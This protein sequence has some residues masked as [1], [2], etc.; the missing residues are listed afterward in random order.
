MLPLAKK[1]NL[2]Y[3]AFGED[4]T[5]ANVPAK[6]RLALT[7]PRFLDPAPVTPTV[8]D[9]AAGYKLLSGTIKST[10]NAHRALRGDN[11][12]V[13]PGMPT[14]NTD[15]RFY[16]TLTSHIFRYNHHGSGKGTNPLSGAHTVNEC[17]FLSYTVRL[18]FSSL[19][20]SNCGG[21]LEIIRFFAT[22][23]LNVDETN[24]L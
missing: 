24:T 7:A 8:G 6:G 13:A 15:T 9:E 11:I 3:N 5:D 10:Y 12:Y 17:E 14:G 22:L 21:F 1:Y 4:L 16:W 2:T 19:G 18:A 20:L 23:I